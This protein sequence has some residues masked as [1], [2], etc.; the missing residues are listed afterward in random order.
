MQ[1]FLPYSDFMWS[2][3]CLDRQRL[4]KQRVEAFQI[5]KALTNPIYGW[6]SHPAVRMWRGCSLELAMYGLVI[7][8]EWVARGY[9]DRLL[10]KFDEYLSVADMVPREEQGVPFWLGD[11][12]F[13]DS[14]KSNL[15]RKNPEHYSQFGWCVTPNL[16]YVWPDPFGG[17]DS[18]M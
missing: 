11:P 18:P 12:A 6:Q 13:H 3:K 7:C 17:G 15:L 9:Q 4:G 1:T 14:H 8:R 5:L 2:A 10:D 16:P